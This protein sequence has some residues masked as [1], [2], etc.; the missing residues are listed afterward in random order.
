MPEPGHAEQSSV[1]FWRAVA[2]ALGAA[3]TEALGMIV[4][5]TLDASFDALCRRYWRTC[6]ALSL[7]LLHILERLQAYGWPST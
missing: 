2:T 1:Q 4:G 6:V 7:R 5:L 3:R